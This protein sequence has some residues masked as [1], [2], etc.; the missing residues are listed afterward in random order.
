VRIR[1][2]ATL[3]LAAAAALVL[4]G[5]AGGSAPE[6]SPTGTPGDLCAAV[7]PAGSAS[8]A[9]TV[10][11]DFGTTASASFGAPLEVSEVER[12]VVT[13]GDG[14]DVGPGDYVSYALTA[15][16]AATGEQIGTAGYDAPLQPQQVSPESVIGQ[17]LGCTPQGSR[18]V[19]T[20]PGDA[21]SGAQVYVFDV[22]AITPEADWCVPGEFDGNAPTVTFGEN[23]A[24]AIAIPASDPPATI[25][26]EVLEEGDGEVVEP[27]D[28]VEVNYT[29]VKWSDGSTFD[30]SW[31]RGESANFTT[32]GVVDGFRVALE[33]QRVGSTVVVAMPPSCG[34]GEKASSQHELAGE[35]LV[36][37]VDIIASERAGQ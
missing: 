23:G 10:E 28:A 17:M 4:A 16:D 13:E 14:D 33:G 12:T 19:A 9:V 2:L 24:P 27:G 30:S 18:V 22:L 29:G 1:P 37:V 6:A 34:Y 3:S 36:F 8:D 26:V 20:L 15:F 25:G 11:G 32:D 31:D 7:A 5:C 21:Q 35:T